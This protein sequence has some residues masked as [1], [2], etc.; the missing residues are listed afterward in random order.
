MNTPHRPIRLSGRQAAL[1]VGRVIF[2]KS[3]AFYFRRVGAAW[4]LV[5]FGADGEDLP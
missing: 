2:R 4:S 5:K 3:Y 1:W